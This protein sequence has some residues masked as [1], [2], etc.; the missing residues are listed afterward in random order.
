M[1][2]FSYKA[3]RRNGELVEGTLDVIDRP[4][5]LAQI[6]RQGLFPIVVDAGKAGA[7]GQRGGKKLDWRMYL[8]QPMR[9]QLQR[10]RKPKL[11]ELATYTQQMAN[12]LQAGM[13]LSTAL[14]SMTYLDSKGIPSDISRQLKQEVTEGRSLS[15]A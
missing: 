10:T 4:T 2:Q 8:P 11:Q 12:L 3:R 15:D 14:N 9:E 13:P 1:P 7:A 6:E 5:A